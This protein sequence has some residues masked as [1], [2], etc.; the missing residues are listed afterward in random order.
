MC[1]GPIS[2]RV[3]ASQ[4]SSL[5]EYCHTALAICR[6]HMLMS[7]PSP[8]LHT[9]NL[10]CPC[11]RTSQCAQPANRQICQPANR[12][13]CRVRTCARA[14]RRLLLHGYHRSL[15]R[16]TPSLHKPYCKPPHEKHC[17]TH[18]KLMSSKPPQI[19]AQPTYE[20]PCATR[21]GWRRCN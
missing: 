12:Q 15:A 5:N 14:M 17:T 16:L 3:S 11:M 6:K 2:T 20:G 13:V 4:A 21:N 10:G 1:G 19:A 8:R 7:G 9:H 18:G